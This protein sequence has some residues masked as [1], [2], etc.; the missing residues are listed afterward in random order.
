MNTN[1]DTK[2]DTIR[3]NIADVAQTG[4]QH[5][6]AAAKRATGWKK[7]LLAALA[8]IALG[9]AAFLEA[10]CTVSYSQAVTPEGATTTEYSHSL[11]PLPVKDILRAEQGK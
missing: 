1:T 8:V 4:A 10:S 9:V 5:A 11:D 7:W 2:A 3:E 6:T